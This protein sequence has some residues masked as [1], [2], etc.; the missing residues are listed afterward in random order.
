VISRG[1]RCNVSR[2]INVR[3]STRLKVKHVAIP[4]STFRYQSCLRRWQLS[5]EQTATKHLAATVRRSIP[6]IREPAVY[7]LQAA[8]PRTSG[9]SLPW[10]E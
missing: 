8:R 1:D 4:G 2:P 3:F 6:A 10:I 5:G 9:S 7:L